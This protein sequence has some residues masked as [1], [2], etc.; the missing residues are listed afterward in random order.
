MRFGFSEEDWQRT[1]E[2]WRRFWKGKLGRPLVDITWTDPAIPAETGARRYFQEYPDTLSGA[3]IVEMETRELRRF[4][5]IG[6]AFPKRFLNFGPGS[7]AS[8]MGS[9]VS[10][11]GATVWF[12]DLGLPLSDIK[13]RMDRESRWYRRVS[14]IQGAA[15]AA[16]GRDLQVSVSDIGGNLDTLA[17]LR[18]AENLLTDLLDEPDLVEKLTREITR[19]W[20]KVYHE[21][22][23]KILARSRGVT[24]WAPIFSEEKSYMFQC[25]FSYMFSPDLFERLVM[26]DLIACCEEIPASFYHL[27]GPAALRHL[28]LLLS[29][30]KLKGVQ[31]IP[32]AGQ[33]ESAEWIDVLKRIRKAGKFCQIGGSPGKLLALKERMDLD[34]FVLKVDLPPETGRAEAEALYKKLII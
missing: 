14:E 17:S 26:P 12:H 2:N 5:W 31:W 9:R 24:P 13:I 1:L 4:R 27:D 11:D 15:L 22:A 21:E 25:D 33:P 20:L 18:G 19:E 29:I 28:D 30:P 23:D 8:Y 6:D 7:M 3:E 16:W 32:G 34:G 10:A